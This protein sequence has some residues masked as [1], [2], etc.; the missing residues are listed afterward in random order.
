MRLF[1][2]ER[3]QKTDQLL[4]TSPVTITGIVVGKFLAALVCYLAS[5]AITVIFAIVVAVYGDVYV[6]QVVGAYIGCIFLGAAYIAVG[7]FISAATENQITAALVSFFALLIL[8]IIDPIA[9]MMP[10]TEV[11]G[12]AAAAILAFAVIL[13]IYLNT[14]NLPIS[15]V[16]VVL[17]AAALIFCWFVGGKTPSLR[18]HFKGLASTLLGWFSVNRR[19]QD[20]A[21]G[22]FKFDSLIYYASFSGFFLFLTVRHIEKR[23]WN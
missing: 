6:S 19:Y 5:L 21:I 1:S 4:L 12:F 23:R 9:Q 13:F 14:K 16:L 15:L 8:Q 7:C 3:R 18:P 11:T 22:L 10:Q 2:E 17:C 20:F